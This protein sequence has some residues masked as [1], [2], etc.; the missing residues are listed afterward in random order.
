M[1]RKFI[2]TACAAVTMNAAVASAQSQYGNY[3]A[4]APVQQQAPAAQP[5][6]QQVQGQIFS[7]PV[8]QGWRCTGESSN[9]VFI[10]APDSSMGIGFVGLERMQVGNSM[11]FIQKIAQIYGSQNVQ[12][13][14]ANR[15]PVQNCD[16]IE[17]VITYVNRGQPWKAWVRVAVVQQNG[18]GNGYMLTAMST[19]EK[20]DGVVSNLKPLCD[21]IQITN[22]TLA[23]DRQRAMANQQAAYAN[24]TANLNHPMD[25]SVTSGYWARQKSQDEASARR[26]DVM[27]D[28][29]RSTDTSTGTVYTHGAAAYDSAGGV[30]NPERPNEYLTPETQWQGR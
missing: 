6:I 19:P 20:F 5:S 13:I 15:L 9:E 2:I 21:R 10:S 26:S 17:A 23:F 4:P 25:D 14:S 29:Y 16:A 24:T 18:F 28:N 11:Q 7:Y 8:P 27:L 1:F 30:V 3:G 22:A 12:V